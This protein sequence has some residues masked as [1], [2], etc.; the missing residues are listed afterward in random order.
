MWLNITGCLCFPCAAYE[1]RHSSNLAL[2]TKWPVFLQNAFGNPACVN[3]T[4]LNGKLR[5]KLWGQTRTKQK[6]EGAMAHPGP[7]LESPLR[8]RMLPQSRF[9][10]FDD[11]K[12]KNF[13]IAL[14]DS[15]V[16]VISCMR[17]P[18]AQELDKIQVLGYIARKFC[19]PT[20]GVGISEKSCYSASIER[21]LVF[22][23]HCTIRSACTVNKQSQW[24][25][26]WLFAQLQY[27]LK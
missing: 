23:V 3:Q 7:P 13:S 8:T 20:S 4:N 17:Q 15:S 11:I 10:A 25:P 16:Y 6:S 14:S 21:V 1:L 22:G 26:R 9:T 18:L 12:S 24:R 5:K 2:L 19:R 27:R